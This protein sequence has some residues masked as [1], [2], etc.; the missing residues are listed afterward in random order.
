MIKQLTRFF[1]NWF[2]NIIS[3]EWKQIIHNWKEYM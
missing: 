3:G 2:R 1:E